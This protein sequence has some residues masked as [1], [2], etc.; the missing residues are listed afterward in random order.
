MSKE[1]RRANRERLRQERLKEQQRAKRNRLLAAIGA[2]VA[3]IAFVVGG[4]YLVMQAS[5]GTAAEEYRGALAPQTLQEDGSVV[6]AVDG[7]QAPVV[8]V[9]ADY[10]CSHCAR[11]EQINGDTLKELAAEGE[12]VV[13]LRPVS[14]FADAGEPA[15]G[16]SLRA[17]AAA[18]AAADHGRFVEY[19]DILFDN[20]PSTSQ[21]GFTVDELVAWGEEVG[22]TD[23][24]FAERVRAESEVVEEFVTNYYPELSTKAQ[25]EIPEDRLQTMRLSDLVEWGEDNG[26]DS[27]FMAGSYVETVLD[28]TAAVNT[29]Y[30]EGD[31]A[32]GGTPSIYVNGE[33]LGNETYSA[34]DFREAVEA[35]PPG[36]VDT[37]PAVRDDAT[38]PSASPSSSPPA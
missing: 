34:T 21:E 25:A 19:N 1:S 8:E 20:Q 32:F 28:A 15:G 30:S 12:A 6:M 17:G 36:E 3:V 27:S 35:A 9:Y 18:R 10:Q 33:L 38:A 14:I 37:L 2:A 11:F 16:N 22:I 4:G 23:P 29:K 31:N 13:H 5:G 24:A 26:V 7:A